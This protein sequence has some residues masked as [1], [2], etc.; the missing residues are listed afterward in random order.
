MKNTDK[1]LS[2][3]EKKK[4]EKK[5]DRFSGTLEGYLKLIEKDKK[6]TVLAHRRLYDTIVSNGITRM[7]KEDSRCSS[8]F[9][10]ES[11][12]TYDYFQ[13]RFFGMERSLAKV[14]RYL[15]SAAMRGEESRLSN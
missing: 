3:I 1:F 11:L 14:M 9:N 15:H 6:I 5:E 13:D 8:L 10:G 7:S 12:R 2:I 4:N